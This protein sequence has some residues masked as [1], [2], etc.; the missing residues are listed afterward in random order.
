MNSRSWCIV[1]CVA[2]AGMVHAGSGTQGGGGQQDP[3]VGDFSY[4]SIPA[5]SKCTTD[6]GVV[7]A[8]SEVSGT[9]TGPASVP[10]DDPTIVPTEQGRTVSPGNYCGNGICEANETTESCAADCGGRRPT[11]TG[12]AI[13]DGSCAPQ[14]FPGSFPVKQSE[15]LTCSIEGTLGQGTSGAGGRVPF[16]TRYAVTHDETPSGLKAK[17][18]S[19]ECGDRKLF[20]ADIEMICGN[21]VFYATKA[22]CECV[23]GG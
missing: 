15:T 13:G 6:S 5:S 12:P 4:N 14:P 1:A 21:G 2:A 9:P 20:Q 19:G 22:D 3:S 16:G 18:T 8:C 11:G 17:L 23:S 10:A 7:A